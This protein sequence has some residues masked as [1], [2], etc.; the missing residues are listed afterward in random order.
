M[1]ATIIITITIIIIPLGLTLA[2]VSY[3]E[4]KETPN[5][6]TY[7]QGKDK[8]EKEKILLSHQNIPPCAVESERPEF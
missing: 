5:S 8:E 6:K 7:P 3:S 4:L 2:P 1:L